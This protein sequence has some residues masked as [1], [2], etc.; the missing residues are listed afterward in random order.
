MLKYFKGSKIIWEKLFCIVQR[1][2]VGNIILY[3]L[4]DT[5]TLVM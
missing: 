1:G 3:K 2:C 4:Y 5:V